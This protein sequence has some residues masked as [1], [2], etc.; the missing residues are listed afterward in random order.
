MEP[1][2]IDKN[3]WINPTCPHCECVMELNY[4]IWTKNSE[5][6]DKLPT[7]NMYCRFC[8]YAVKVTP[9]ILSCDSARSRNPTTFEC[10]N[11]SVIQEAQQ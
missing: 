11:T 1:I 10:Y 4:S 3:G 7:L 9:T 6:I 2:T 8:H 5:F